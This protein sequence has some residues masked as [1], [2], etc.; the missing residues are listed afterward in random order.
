M[1][2]HLQ[3]ELARSGMVVRPSAVT[4]LNRFVE[5]WAADLRQ[6]S[7]I[8]VFL[9]AREAVGRCARPEFARVA[10]MPGFC[11]ALAGRIEELSAAGCDAAALARR[12]PEAPLAEAFA[13]VYAEF[14]KLLEER[15]L[16]MRAQRLARAAERIAREGTA[17]AGVILMD[18]F[19]TLPPPELAVVRALAAHADVTFTA[20]DAAIAGGM[21]HDLRNSGFT[22]KRLEA[23]AAPARV[24]KFVAAT[25]EREADEIARRILASRRMFREAAVIV[26]NPEIYGPVLRATFER[27]GIPARFYLDEALVRQPAVRHISG[28]IEAL[29]A[30]W[31]HASLLAALKLAP[32]RDLDWFD[33]TLR[34]SLPGKGLDSLPELPGKLPEYLKQLD[35]WRSIS[36][37]PAEW[38][39]RFRTLR[40]LVM[41]PRMKD[42]VPLQAQVEAWRAQAE[43]LPAFEA[44]IDDAAAAM[45]RSPM[46]LEPFWRTAS[47]AIA[48]AP[49]RP[50]DQRRDVVHVLTAYEARQWKTPLVFVC[51]LVEK[52]FPKRA[53]Q[54]AF[55]PDAARRRLSEAGIRLRTT[56]DLD[57]EERWLFDTALTRAT[58]AVAL[59]YPRADPRGEQ[60][61][62]SVF[63]DETAA[64]PSP[65]VAV[66]PG[67]RGAACASA[68][69]ILRSPG[70]IAALAERHASMKTT[71]LESFAQCPFQFFARYTLRL[72]EPPQRPEERLSFILKG[73]VMHELLAALAAV[74]QPLEPLFERIFEAACLKERVLPGYCTERWK[75]EMLEDARRFLADSQ[76]PFLNPART[77]WDVVVPLP[78]GTVVK[79][80][81]DR[82]DLGPEKRAYVVDY[83]YSPKD[84]AKNDILL[85]GPLYLAAVR[86]EGYEPGGMFYCAIRDGV[87]YSGW[88]DGRL[89]MKATPLAPEW[90]A[91][92]VERAAD[93]AARIRAGVIAPQ[94]YDTD[95]CRYCDFRDV[96]RHRAAAAVGAAEAAG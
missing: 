85:Q 45:P 35:A 91:A 86:Q 65:V 78:D 68:P 66:R 19:H 77:E 76:W 61:I 43:A 64:E 79:G 59:S 11:S 39:E 38:A 89:G 90:I 71:A 30:E 26:R 32:C 53:P 47:D 9:I 22:E 83:K 7:S 5:P 95:A 93:Y 33:F 2:Q 51:G 40:A 70:S 4:T 96:C 41:A 56:R 6:A 27:F 80:R 23:A 15:G 52:Q 24:E 14:E 72:K 8:A 82:M 60:N 84:H 46:A 21:R 1:A 10:H 73:V 13:A 50:R 62:P 16:A 67:R 20:P 17:G 34:A 57:E 92:G 69:P 37:T 18:G 75:Q 3:H 94:P 55:F 63:L 25:I 12:L 81:I 36:C 74:P 42:A 44:A 58:E 87:K 88:C 49:L 29:L 31:E 48:M 54:D 28:V